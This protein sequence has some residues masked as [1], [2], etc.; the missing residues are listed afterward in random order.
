M[1]WRGDPPA[2]RQG[3]GSVPM[4]HGPM[5]VGSPGAST[6]YGMSGGLCVAFMYLCGAHAVLMRSCCG[7]S[8]SNEVRL[9]YSCGANVVLA[10]YPRGAGVVVVLVW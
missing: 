8:G 9:W 4:A 5:G 6:L 7:V 2:L 10:W 3:L 1:G